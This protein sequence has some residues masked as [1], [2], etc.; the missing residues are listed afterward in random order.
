MAKLPRV[1]IGGTAFSYQYQATPDNIPCAD[2]LRHA[3]TR[4]ITAI[5]T[6]RYYGPSEA[7]LGKALE[8]IASDWPRSSYFLQTKCGRN[9]IDEFDY[10]PA[11]IEQS[12]R[13]S[14]ERLRTKYLDCVLLHDV[15]FVS[16][17]Q[18]MEAVQVLFRLRD[19][20]FI[21]KIGISGLPI[22]LLYQLAVR[23]LLYTGR[24]LDVVLSYCNLTLQNTAL[25]DYVDQFTRDARVS[26]L[27][28]ASPLAMGLLRSQDPPAWHPASKDLREA[29]R[30]ASNVCGK[31]HGREL[32]N[33]ALE[34]TFSKW[35]Q[36]STIVGMDSIQQVDTVLNAITQPQ[37]SADVI[38]DIQSILEPYHNR[39][40]PSPPESYQHIIKP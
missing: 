14:M 22:D 1:I 16:A 11:W 18:V 33:V 8:E 26:T 25:L 12:V 5:D 32:A 31:V 7:I 27:L 2:L 34:Y 29:V 39:L 4:G 28:N 19:E 9:G 20:G 15:E 23:I 35:S 38:Y 24:P 13:E 6:A 36:G 21:R 30:H 37:N 40:W 3:F 17:D 10:S